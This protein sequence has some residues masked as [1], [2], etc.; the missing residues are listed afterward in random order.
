[1]ALDGVSNAT[2]QGVT[3]RMSYSYQGQDLFVL[4]VLGGFRGGF[5]LDSGASNGT[6]GN[7]TY[8]LERDYGW[9]GICVEPN[10]V[11]YRELRGVRRCVCA[12]CCL[13][14]REGD[15]EFLEVAGVYGGILEAYDPDHLRFTSRVLGHPSLE[16]AELPTTRKPAR[17]VRS[18]LREAAAPPI[19]DYWSLDTEGSELAI[20]RSFPFD[21]YRFR[22]LTVEHN[23]GAAREKIRS[24]LATRGYTR[25]RVLG[26][27]DGYV[28]NGEPVTSAWR[29][30]AWSNGRRR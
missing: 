18:I 23:D 19:I 17:T 3:D 30:G 26:I 29:S 16:E 4:E 2:E 15:V 7:N 12:H 25:M 20:L 6:K 5:F 24:Y 1:L 21:E 8:L 9:A 11:L 14:D 13:Y 27:D 28:W 22:V 10:D